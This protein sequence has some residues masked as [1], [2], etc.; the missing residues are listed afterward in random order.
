MQ[1]RKLAGVALRQ[2]FRTTAAGVSNILPSFGST[3]VT[4]LLIAP[5]DI[6]TSD[7]TIAS[8]IH[9]GQIKL[10]GKLMET[11]GASPFGIPCPSSAFEESLHSFEWLRHFRATDSKDVSAHSRT[12]VASWIDSKQIKTSAIARR[13]DVTARRLISWLSQSS[14]LLEGVDGAF[15]MRFIQSISSDAKRLKQAMRGLPSNHILLLSQI[16]LTHFVVSASESDAVIKQEALRLCELL[17]QQIYSD[18]GCF[19]LAA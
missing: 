18:G 1:D 3:G 12:L 10:A 14:I 17:D 11:H 7:P 2:L 8:E 6:R 15:Y 9:A 5:Q 19:K 16:A 4:K 13:A